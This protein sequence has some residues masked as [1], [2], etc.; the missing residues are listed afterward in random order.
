MSER[1]GHTPPHDSQTQRES[2]PSPPS[3]SSSSTEVF[4]AEAFARRRRFRLIGGLCLCFFV[5][6]LLWLG[7]WFFF[8][9]FEEST[10]DAYVAGNLVRVSPLVNGSVREILADN[11][12]AV[13]AGQ[14]LVR[15]DSTDAALALERARSSLADTVR[16]IRS[17]MA[18][19][20][21]LAA[22]V[23]LRQKEL[24]KAR[25]NLG[26]RIKSKTSLAVSEEE[27][28]HAHDNVSMAET[29]LTVARL[30]L[31]VNRML[32]QDKALREQPQVLLRVQMLREAW[33]A[34]KR[35]DIQSPVDGY[36]A[37]RS[38]QVGA[39]V[40]PGMAL[41]AVIPLNEIWVDANFKEVQ[42]ARMRIGQKAVIEADVYGRS[43]AYRGEVFGFAAG[44]GSAFSLL[45]PENATGN[46]IKVVQRVPVK[47]CLSTEQL[48][49]APLLIGLSCKVVVDVSDDRGSMLAPLPAQNAEA[50]QKPLYK[51]LALEYDLSEVNE[52]IERIIL[53]NAA[54]S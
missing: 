10:D 54:G 43:I 30:Q 52:E 16:Q 17:L 11:T 34:F 24:D 21:R 36:V 25:G 37:K 32:L 14:V 39:Y 50:E 38:V 15:L 29:A 44:T 40:T 1:Q 19:S 28:S 33:L 27:L 35:C 42:I 6:G 47:I 49:A 2:L 51:T 41:M 3:S 7:Y 48:A 12:Q 26:R 8:L 53:S 4:H 18:E 31:Q 13:T 22:V 46:W 20:E 5:I 9:R 23:L 45:P